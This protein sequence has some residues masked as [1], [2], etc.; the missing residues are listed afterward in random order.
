[1][2]LLP[3]PRDFGPVCVRSKQTVAFVVVGSN[4][5]P[6]LKTG[7]YPGPQGRATEAGLGRLGV[8]TETLASR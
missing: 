7:F 5:H 4:S 3:P 2:F 8:F 6:A 1:M